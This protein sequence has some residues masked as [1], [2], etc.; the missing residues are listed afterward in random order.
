MVK[1]VRGYDDD[2]KVVFERP[3][4]EYDKSIAKTTF[5]ISLGDIVKAIPI[6]FLCGIVYAH[7]QEFD[8][9][10]LNS[11]NENSSAVTSIKMVLQHLDN[12]LTKI[13]GKQFQDGLPI[14]Q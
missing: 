1:I 13:T 3:A 9:R 6:I 5:G 4:R 12:S 11:M 7:Q 8:S 14:T 10:M 2:E